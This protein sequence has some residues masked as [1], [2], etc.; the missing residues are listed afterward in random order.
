MVKA[1]QPDREDFPVVKIERSM[2]RD[3]DDRGNK[4]GY[5]VTTTI[6]KKLASEVEAAK[7]LLA[8]SML[9]NEI[10]ALLDGMEDP[11]KGGV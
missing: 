9:D 5:V 2:Y 4:S 1:R 10:Q 6:T 7:Y 11:T 8:V 3:Y